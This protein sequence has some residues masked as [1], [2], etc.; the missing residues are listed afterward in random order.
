[1]GDTL[2][3]S[4]RRNQVMHKL[5]CL[6]NLLNI[7][8]SYTSQFHT[9]KPHISSV[10]AHESRLVTKFYKSKATSAIIVAGK[11]GTIGTIN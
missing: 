4:M 5:T 8:D 1:M 11:G 6:H 2:H 7:H 3:V 9:Y 10:A